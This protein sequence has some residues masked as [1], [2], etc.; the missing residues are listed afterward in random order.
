MRFT[1][2]IF[3]AFS[4]TMTALKGARFADHIAF[5]DGCAVVEVEFRTVRDVGGGIDHLGVGIDDTHFGHSSDNDFDVAALGIHFVGLY[6]TELL[7]F[8]D[9]VV[10]RGYGRDGRDIRGDTTDVE[11][12]ERKLSTRLTD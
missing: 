11:R 1:Y 9:T 8:E 12:T 5:L 4:L 10:T 3:P 2:W 6:L 7:D